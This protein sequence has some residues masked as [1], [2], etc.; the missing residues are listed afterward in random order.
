MRKWVQLC[1]L[2]GVLAALVGCD[3]AEQTAQKLAEKAEQAVQDVAREAVDGALQGLNEQIDHVQQSA[4]ELL[5]KPTDDES[6]E[7]TQQSEVP[8]DQAPG[9]ASVET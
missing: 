2:S 9:A 6:Q 5:G 1:A 4:N 8:A 3:A 7:Q